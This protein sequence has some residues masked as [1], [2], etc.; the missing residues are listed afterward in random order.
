VK[1]LQVQ[2]S[3]HFA[4]AWGIDARLSFVPSNSTKGWQGKWNLIILDTSDEAGALGYHDLTPEGLPVGKVFAK[5]DQ[6]YGAA[7][8]VTASHE[9]T[10]M[11]LDP[12][13]NLTVMDPRRQVFVAYEAADAVE[14]D[15]LGYRVNGVLL[16]DFVLPPFFDPQ[17]LGRKGAQFSWM[18]H[19]AAPFA[20]APGGYES[21]FVP[22]HGWTQHTAREGGALPGDRP[23]VGSRRERR[24]AAF[25]SGLSAWNRSPADGPLPS[26]R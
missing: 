5:T 8:S 3:E 1:A 18:G 4:A 24:V 13:V 23:K 20:L 16:S 25:E 21:M 11:M 14:A 22:G 2:A 7:W 17:A 6:Q 26:E 10:E 9:L 12:F 19:V 15:D